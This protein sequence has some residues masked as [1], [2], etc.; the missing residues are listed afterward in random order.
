MMNWLKK[1]FGGV[2]SESTK[3]TASGSKVSKSFGVS[4]DDP[5]PCHQPIGERAILDKLRCKKH[6]QP[7]NYRRTG[8]VEKSCPG[9]EEHENQGDMPLDKY[10]LVCKSGE[11][12]HELFFCMYHPM[13][14]DPAAPAG[15]AKKKPG[16]GSLLEQGASFAPVHDTLGPDLTMS[17]GQAVKDDDE[18]KQTMILRQLSQIGYYRCVPS[19]IRLRNESGSDIAAECQ[20]A[21]DSFDPEEVKR[22]EAMLS[23]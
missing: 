3:H 13:S 23:G 4:P 21:L 7:F 2:K 1:L 11:C 20:A 15:L 10:D 5:I 18:E 9:A 14:G 22:R 19:L 17:L 8:P 16:M 6:D 12:K